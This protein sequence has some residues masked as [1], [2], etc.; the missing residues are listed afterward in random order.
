MC[1]FKQRVFIFLNAN[2]I[3]SKT[4]FGIISDFLIAQYINIAFLYVA[5]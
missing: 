2:S 3:Y 1:N 5:L 4:N